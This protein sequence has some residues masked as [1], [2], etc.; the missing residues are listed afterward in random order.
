MARHHTRVRALVNTHCTNRGACGLDTFASQYLHQQNTRN[1]GI[2]GGLGERNSH[3]TRTYHMGTHSFCSSRWKGRCSHELDETPRHSAAHTQ[4][5]R[6]CLKRSHFIT[7]G[8]IWSAV[9]AVLLRVGVGLD[10]IGYA[11]T[12]EEVMPLVPDGRSRISHTRRAQAR[13]KAAT[14][15]M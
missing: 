5:Y 4:T 1:A 10:Q 13:H 11:R 8:R 7:L 9:G 12:C 3:T 15:S 6:L 2:S 14:Y